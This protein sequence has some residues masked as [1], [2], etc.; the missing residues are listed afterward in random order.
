MGVVRIDLDGGDPA[1]Q[2]KL[3]EEML[4]RGYV[5]TIPGVDSAGE[6]RTFA[7][8]PGH[9][10]HHE[11]TSA[12]EMVRV[13]TAALEALGELGA[14]VISTSGDSS[15]QGLRMLDVGPEPDE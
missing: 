3:D 13:A 1:R 10:W 11:P 15:H 12:L 9:Y 4:T 8:P 6:E 14:A 5:T 2:A 7:L